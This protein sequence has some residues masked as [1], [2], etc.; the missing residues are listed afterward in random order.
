MGQYELNPVLGRGR[1]GGRQIGI[2]V[3]VLGSAALVQLIIA[4]RHPEY[5]KP[6]AYVNLG[7]SAVTGAVAVSN[8]KRKGR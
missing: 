7:Y 6:L 8:A 5:G 2:K 1:F 4:G 3:G